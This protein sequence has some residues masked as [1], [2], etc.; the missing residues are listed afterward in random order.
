MLTSALNEVQ[1][2]KRKKEENIQEQEEKYDEKDH[3]NASSLGAV[4]ADR[5]Y[6]DREAVALLLAVMTGLQS[7]EDEVPRSECITEEPAEKSESYV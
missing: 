4:L 3:Q 5:T 2:A 6:E 1:S 7:K